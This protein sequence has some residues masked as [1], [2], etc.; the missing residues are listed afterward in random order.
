MLSEEQQIEKLEKIKEV[1]SLFLSED[2]L[3]IRDVSETTGISHSSVQR[4]LHDPLIN[5]IFGA[6]AKKIIGQ[7]EKKLSENYENGIRLGG[8]TFVN[9]NVSLKDEYGHFIGSKKR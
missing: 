5:E 7:I 8:E 2:N 1:V 4:Y 9:N 6:D 3:T